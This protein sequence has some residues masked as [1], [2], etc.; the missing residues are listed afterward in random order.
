[1]TSR[2]FID[3]L[4]SNE[5]IFDGKIKRERKSNEKKAEQKI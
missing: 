1:M 5:I 3:A 4:M 2:Q